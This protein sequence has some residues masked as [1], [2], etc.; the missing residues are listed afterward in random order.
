[1]MI[2]QSRMKPITVPVSYASPCSPAKPE[3][4]CFL[5]AMLATSCARVARGP[6]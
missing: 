6:R 5:I 4:I 3:L 2:A 1:M